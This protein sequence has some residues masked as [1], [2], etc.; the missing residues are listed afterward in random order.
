M[1]RHCM[2]QQAVQKPQ[3]MRFSMPEMAERGNAKT[4]KLHCQEKRLGNLGAPKT[5]QVMAQW[6]EKGRGREE[7]HLW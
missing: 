7:R 5:G 4:W 2:G 3:I 6:G 1:L